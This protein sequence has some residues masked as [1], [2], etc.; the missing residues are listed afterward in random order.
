MSVN[1]TAADRVGGIGGY[2]GGISTLLGLMGNGGI[3]GGGCCA[4]PQ[5]DSRYCEVHTRFHWYRKRRLYRRRFRRRGTQEADGQSCS[6]RY[7]GH[8]DND[9]R[10]VR[11]GQAD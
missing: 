8:R 6:D 1:F 2:I 5:A 10:Q 3:L 9:D 7:P 11:G 4:L